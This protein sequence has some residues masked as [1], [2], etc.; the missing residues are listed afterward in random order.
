M[1]KHNTRRT[2]RQ[3]KPKKKTL[4]EIR[5]LAS[6]K[7]LTVGLDLGDRF[8]NY[9]ILDA[10]SNVL[11]EGKLATTRTGFNAI[12]E[13]LGKLRIA[14]E[15]GTHSPWVSRHL[16]SLGHEVIVANP[17]LVSIIGESK[18]KNDRVDA[19]KLARLA[20]ADPK[21]LFPIQHRGEQ[22][23]LDL[24]QIRM[25]E[26]L[27]KLRTSAINAAR[28]QAKTLGYR[29]EECDSDNAGL[30]LAEKLPEAMQKVLNPLLETAAQLTAQIKAA[31]REIHSIAKRYGEIELL[32][33]IYGVGELTALAFVLTIDDK[34][35]F[36]KSREVGPYLGMVPGQNQSGDSNPQQRITKEGDRMVRWLL[37]QCAHCIL[38][39][40][41]PD[42]DL[43]RWGMKKLEEQ[44]TGKGKPNVKKVLIGVARKLA[45]LMHRLWANGEVYDPLYNAKRQEALAKRTAA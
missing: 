39:N 30:Q 26:E 9:C 29:L 42:T 3:E 44:Q 28:G 14:L 5:S 38:K 7:Q 1:K 4:Q 33:A 16:S 25:R 36:G 22:T 41:A 12:F 21:L 43:R 8:S 13:R 45:V 18:H 15:A 19:E 37:V 17:R 35:R 20:R 11:F 23:Q 27:V 31:D 2:A 40:G 6:E 24:A 32:T 34:E 10:E